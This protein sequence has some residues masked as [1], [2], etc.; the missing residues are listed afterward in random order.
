[1][2]SIW[3]KLHTEAMKVSDEAALL[4][5]QGKKDLARVAYKAAAELEEQ[6]LKALDP[7]KVR[8]IAITRASLEAL[9]EKSQN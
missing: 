4:L 1:M 7:S 3:A 9:R 6:A 8:T 5:K 2:M